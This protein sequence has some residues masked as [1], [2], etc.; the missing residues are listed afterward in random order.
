MPPRNV[1][2]HHVHGGLFRRKLVQVHEGQAQLLGAGLRNVAFRAEGRLH[3][4]LRKRRSR[5]LRHL[6]SLLQLLGREIPFLDKVLTHALPCHDH[7]V[8]SAL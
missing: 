8:P 2:G 5:L 6:L 4:H 3:Q 1:L 7:V